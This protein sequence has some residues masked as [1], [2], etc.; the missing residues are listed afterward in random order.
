MSSTS[1][2]GAEALTVSG[3]ESLPVV[4]VRASVVFSI[5]SNYVRRNEKQERVIGTLLGT[6][7]DG[8]IVE[9]NLN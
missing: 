7:K 8:N 1:S 9:V 3:D 4:R 5:L 2:T 6:V